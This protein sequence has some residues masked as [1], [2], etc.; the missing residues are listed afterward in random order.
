[1][2]SIISCAVVVVVSTAWSE[3]RLHKKD[4]KITNI[5]KEYNKVA[6]SHNDVLDENHILAFKHNQLVDKYNG[7][8]KKHNNLIEKYDDLRDITTELNDVI[9]LLHEMLVDV[10][11]L[12][13]VDQ[14]YIELKEAKDQKDIN[15]LL[16]TKV[17][18]K[19][20]Q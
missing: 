20:K 16:K 11:G 12:E 9:D 19:E 15:A 1:M 13:K 10:H 3:Y 4:K 2:I 5:S 18:A 14:L 17:K 6:E 7:L 8:A